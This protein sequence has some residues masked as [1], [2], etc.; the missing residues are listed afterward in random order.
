MRNKTAFVL[1]NGKSISRRLFQKFESK[2]YHDLICADGGA[3]LAYKMNLKPKI[4][5]GDLDSVQDL[6][7]N[8]YKSIAKIIYLKRQTDTDLEKALIFCKQRKYKNVFV[9]GFSGK[10]FDHTLSSI[11]NALK[12]SDYFRIVLVDNYSAIQF[13]S[14]EKKFNSFSGEMVSLFGISD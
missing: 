12:F 10:R 4:I 14:C 2:Y 6:V 8:H 1:C 11:S 7:L 9:F 3:N 13:I 5:I